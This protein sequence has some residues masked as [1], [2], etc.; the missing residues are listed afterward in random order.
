M[1]IFN[2]KAVVERR[3]FRPKF[4]MRVR[5][6]PFDDSEMPSVSRTKQRYPVKGI[7]KNYFQS[8]RFGVP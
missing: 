3:G 6:A 5:L 7:G 2:S 4:S 1:L 8:L